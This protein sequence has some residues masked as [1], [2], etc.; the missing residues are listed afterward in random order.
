MRISSHITALALC[1][2]SAVGCGGSSS[3]GGTPVSAADFPARFASDWCA[4]MKRCC[5]TSG[6]TADQACETMTAAQL[7]AEGNDAVADGATWNAAAAEQCLQRVRGADC[8]GT[9]VPKLV[10][11]VDLC[12][13]IWTG[14]VPPGGACRT[15]LSCAEPPV[16]GGATAGS[17]CGNSVC[18]AVVR[19][20]VGATCSTT[21]TTM[22]CDP[23]AATCSGGVCVAL[24]G[25][26]EECHGECL[27][28]LRCTT[29]L[30]GRL[31]GAGDAC[32]A[33]NE[34]ASERCSGGKCASVLAVSDDYCTL[35]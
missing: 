34:C 21:A 30:C 7:T 25:L 22:L 14:V 10:A 31:L 17:S 5:E 23:L 33:N 18:I 16:S 11:L 19:Q 3:G 27:P 1:G 26:A 8:A 35:P 28:G 2:L 29:Y 24:P 13:D 6:G 20:P 12:A 4:M 9:D 32:N 15:Y